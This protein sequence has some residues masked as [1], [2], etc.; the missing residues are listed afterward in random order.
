V[1]EAAGRIARK[2][3]E[4]RYQWQ[5]IAEDIEQAYYKILDGTVEPALKKPSTRAQEVSH[6]Q[7]KRRAG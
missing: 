1:R 4:E 6:P 2:R 7:T 5:K 3:I